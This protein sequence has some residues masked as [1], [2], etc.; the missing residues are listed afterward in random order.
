M[1]RR[2]GLEALLAFGEPRQRGV[3]LLVGR[4]DQQPLELEVVD[5][6]RRNF[7]QG[8]QFDLDH[9]VPAGPAFLQ[10]DLGL[11]RRSQFLL[12]DQLL[13]A[14]LNGALQRLL[15]DR[16]PGHLPD[17]DVRHLSGAEA[18]HA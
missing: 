12:R 8:F 6:G 11:H 14:F 17:E 9:R 18:G 10:L 2:R 3:D 13:D 5:P 16:G 7:G 1:R 15:L 4:L